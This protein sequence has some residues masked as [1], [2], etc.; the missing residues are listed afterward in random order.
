MT[1]PYES[2][3]AAAKEA[4]PG[5]HHIYTHWRD[6]NN[7]QANEAWHRAA[8]PQLITA[9]LAERDAL[10]KDAERLN[11]L[12]SQWRDGVQLE[13]CAK[14][15]GATWHTLRREAAIYDRT[16]T[17][18]TGGTAREAIDA[19]MDQAAWIQDYRRRTGAGL[20]EAVDAA[21]AKEPK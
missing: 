17:I 4:T 8:E 18:S 14:N 15:E 5:P 12:D 16:S 21:L 9:L 3:R 13:V 10:L 7:W 11:W 19:G 6:D 20:K 2:L 1:D